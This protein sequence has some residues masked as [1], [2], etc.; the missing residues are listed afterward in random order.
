VSDNSFSY[1]YSGAT[2]DELEMFKE[3][4]TPKHTT[5]KMKEIRSL[6]KRIDF[7][8]TMISIAIGLFG[9]VALV[10]GTIMLI[11]DQLSV[12][13]NGVL[14]LGGLLIAATNHLVYGRIHNFFKSIYAPKI[15]KLIQEIENNTL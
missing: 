1:S 4:Y 11:K 2:K 5:E 6:D 8:A 10:M 14:V 15:L 7:I 9:S 3:K 12:P 13:F